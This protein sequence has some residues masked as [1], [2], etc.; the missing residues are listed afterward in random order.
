MTTLKMN[1]LGKLTIDEGKPLSFAVKV[2]DVSLNGIVFSLDKNNPIGAKINSSTGMFMWTPT[3]LQGAKSYVFD[4]VV[5]LGSLTDRQPITI[6]VNDVLNKPEP[7]KTPEPAKEL[8]LAS[9]VDTSKDPQSY[10][11]RYNKE[12]NYKKWFDANFP[13]YSSIYEAVGLDEPK[14]E[15]P[16]VETAKVEKPQFG[17]CGTGTKLIDGMC[18]IIEIPKAKP[19]WKFW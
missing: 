10:V 11:D 16:K 3:D 18:T 17:I 9:F 14:P 2:T 8:G 19:W 5:T 7:A 12:P 1:P 13:E 15:T 4:I 6:T